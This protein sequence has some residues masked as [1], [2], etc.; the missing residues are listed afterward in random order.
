VTFN[1]APVL[2][3]FLASL[4][5][6]D[7]RNTV[8]IAID[9][10]STDQTVDVLERSALPIRL[11]RNPANLGFAA[12]ANRGIRAALELGCEAVLLLNNDTE[13]DAGLFDLLRRKLDRHRCDVISPKI[14][15]PGGKLWYG[16]GGFSR[17]RGYASEHYGM[18]RSDRG[19]FD[20]ALEVD[21]A[22][23]CCLLIRSKVFRN[24]GYF[25]ERYFVYFEDTDFCFRVRR[26]GHT[27]VYEP[28]ARIVHQGGAST[29]GD[30]SEFSI[31]FLTRNHVYFLL[32][33]AGLS[34]ALLCLPL[35]QLLLL[36]RA[37]RGRSARREYGIAQRA[38]IEGIWT[39]READATLDPKELALG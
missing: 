22:P 26:A 27:I 16:G 9:N 20:R 37:L 17:L 11:V 13:F 18:H 8:L 39:Y 6:Q 23:A 24:V 34:R 5:R 38:L 31:R 10:A 15:T 7:L 12:A 36:V 21:F 19:Q 14:V 3:G 29:G 32:K 30:A 33:N 2:P 35:Y 28:A 1:A 25:D 4:G